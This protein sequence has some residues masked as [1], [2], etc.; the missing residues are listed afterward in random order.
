MTS[1]FSP[2]KITNTK[3]TGNGK[4]AILSWPVGYFWKKSKPHYY[5]SFILLVLNFQF[6][7]LLEI[8]ALESRVT[9]LNLILIILGYILV[10]SCHFKLF[11]TIPYE[12]IFIYVAHIGN[13]EQ[14]NA[15]F[16]ISLVA[17]KYL[18]T[19]SICCIGNKNLIFDR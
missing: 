11:I 16:K 7:D 19:V 5:L 12:N 8:K 1:F 15:E 18:W 17:F 9:N 4:S 10:N 6:Q 3:H 14:L 13:I 2:L